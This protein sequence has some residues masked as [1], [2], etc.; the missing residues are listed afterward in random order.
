MKIISR[1]RISNPGG[2]PGLDDYSDI[3]VKAALAEDIGTGD[4]TTDA[5]VSGRARGTAVFVAKEDCVLAGVFIAEKTFKHL[6]DGISFNAFF[7]D[8]DRVKKG[9]KIAEVSGGLAVILKGERV[10]L[11]FLQRLSGIATNTDRYVRKVAGTKA[12]V[13][14]TRKTTPCLRILEKYAVKTGGGYN[15]RFG[16]FDAILIKDN[17]IKAAGSVKKAVSRVNRRY[18]EAVVVEVETTNLREVG[19]A[20]SCGADIIMLDN[21][22]ASKIKKALKIIKGRALVEASGGITIDNIEEVAGTGVDF[23]SVGGLTHSAKA[24]DISLEVVS[25][26][27]RK[28][29][30]RA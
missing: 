3:L 25:T 16:L 19:E 21:M 2:V 26:H 1:K 12:K 13:L 9:G 24:V 22:D 27:A 18:G 15:H 30:H 17:H 7:K 4:I 8:G 28:R 29:G 5:T 23:I 14:D 20:L 6:A 11:N 10:A